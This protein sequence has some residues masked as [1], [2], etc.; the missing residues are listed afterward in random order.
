VGCA[1]GSS[2]V[3]QLLVP[4]IQLAIAASTDVPTAIQHQDLGVVPASESALFTE[5]L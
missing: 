1:Q 4:P 5:V 3:A 2:S